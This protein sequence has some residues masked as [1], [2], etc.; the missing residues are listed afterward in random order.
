MK[1]T[2]ISKISTNDDLICVYIASPYT[3][4]N[5]AD[6][7]RR[8]HVTMDSLLNLGYFTFDALSTYNIPS[9]L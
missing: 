9:T 7:V 5:Q 3:I 8:Q 4:E 2:N 1:Q 6:N